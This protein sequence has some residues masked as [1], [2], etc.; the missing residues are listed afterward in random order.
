MAELKDIF[1]E[2][3][4]IAFDKKHRQTLN[5]NISKYDEA[6]A[7]GKL[8]YRNMEL[9][10]ERAS[11]LKGKIVVHLANY[12]EE[13][14][15]NAQNNGIEVIWA[16]DSKEAVD[17]IIKVLHAVDAKLLVK[18]KSMISEEIELNENLEHSGFEPVET[19]LGEFI[20]QVAGEKPYHI[21]TPAMHKSKE[22]VAELFHS[23]FN[24]PENSTPEELTAFVRQVLR[25]KFTS[26]EVGV[27]GSN[28]L[29]A[30]VGGVALTENEGNGLMSISFPKVHIAITGIEKII[31]SVNDLPLFFPLLSA[32][33]TGQQVTV[34]NSLLTGPKRENETSGPEKMFVV[35]LDNNRTKIANQE[36]HY[37]ALKCLR[38]G[39]CLN[40]CPI[41]K[42]IGGY[43]YNTTYSGPIGSV[44]TPFMKGFDAYDHLSFASSLCGACSE[45]CP[46]KIPLHKLLLLNR[47]MSIE[48]GGGSFSW[49]TGM[50]AYEWAFKKRN[51]LDLL[52]GKTKNMALKLNRDVLG[53]KKEFPPVA[54]HSFSKKWSTN[55]K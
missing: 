13:F 18:S 55:N 8:R 4:K 29:V 27:T 40:A 31:P 10:K 17:E 50:K 9:A 7:K 12:L 5:F 2:D 53:S 34:Y 28:F 47:K 35:L 51:N 41:Y 39:A 44:I 23:K 36:E 25:K 52:S 20:V 37:E 26:A 48:K 3:S 6:V 1:L 38:C 11:Y 43:A 45:V 24:T 33:G 14:E 19:D 46:V 32:L 16:R 21:L 42:N 30:D 49:N 15:R 54:D 22:D